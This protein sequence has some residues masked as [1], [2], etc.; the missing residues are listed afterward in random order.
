MMKPFVT[1]PRKHG[2]FTLIELLV[3]IAIIAILAAILFPV[4]AQAREKARQTSCLSNT[5]Q[6]GSGIMMYTQDYDETYP[7]AMQTRGTAGWVNCWAIVTQP[8]VKTY[9][10]FRCPSDTDFTSKAGWSWVEANISYAPNSYS[11]GCTDLRGPVGGF[12]SCLVMPS[13]SLGE[14]SR[15]ADTILLAERHNSE[16]VSF[17]GVGNGIN[18]NVGIT[19]QSW[20]GGIVPTTLPDGSRTTTAKDYPNGPNGVVTARHG[21]MANFLFCD[22][23]AKAMKPS[24]TNPQT[25]GLTAAQKDNLN[26]WDARRQ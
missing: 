19:G 6:M 2:A 25:A 3:V 8:Y 14:I 23:H 1:S 10:I 5:K 20:L 17:G 21:E 18:Y 26:L 24:A 13:K 22:G 7:L 9:D 12:S 4:F 11:N 15:V 16:V